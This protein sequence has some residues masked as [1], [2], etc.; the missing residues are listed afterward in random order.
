[1]G[2]ESVTHAVGES[3]FSVTKIFTYSGIAI[4]FSMLVYIMFTIMAASGH[5]ARYSN[6]QDYIADLDNLRGIEEIPI[7]YT[8]RTALG[9]S[10]SMLLAVAIICALVSSVLV[11][12]RS[13]SRVLSIIAKYELLPEKYSH[14]SPDGV[15]VNACLLILAVSVPMPFLG[16]AVISWNADVSNISMAVVYAYISIC[17][18]K[19]VKKHS[20]RYILGIAGTLL[21]F[22]ILGFLLIPNVRYPVLLLHLLSR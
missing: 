10:G 17:T 16:R 8:V 22:L 9:P 11:F 15:P 6:W 18:F 3:R 12:Y 14:L 20:F 2:F 5:P 4:I 1:M 19:T 13:A 7:I 21:S